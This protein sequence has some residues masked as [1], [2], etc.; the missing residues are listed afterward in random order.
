MIT[1]D[2]MVK[3]FSDA[4]YA[5]NKGQ[6]KD[7]NKISIGQKIKL[8]DGTEHEVQRGDTMTSIAQDYNNAQSE[9][10]KKETEEKITD[11]PQPVQTTESTNMKK[12]YKDVEMI[13]K[14]GKVK[15]NASTLYPH[16]IMNKYFNGSHVCHNE[17][18]DLTEGQWKVMEE[19]MKALGKIGIIK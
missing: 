3:A 7:I 13:L 12:V 1:A 2:K 5:L 15:V 11:R 17:V 9:R 6:I 8:P 16:E 4:A 10:A 18:D 14:E 19:K